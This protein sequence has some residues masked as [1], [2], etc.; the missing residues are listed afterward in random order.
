M[1]WTSYKYSFNESLLMI[2]F[3]QKQ[4]VKSLDYMTSVKFI[5]KI[6]QR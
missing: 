3:F 2:Q 5:P 6:V 1:D 4:V